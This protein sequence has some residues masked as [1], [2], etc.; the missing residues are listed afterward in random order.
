MLDRL[1]LDKT[2]FVT[3]RRKRAKTPEMVKSVPNVTLF[4]SKH[5][6]T[7]FDPFSTHLW[8]KGHLRLILSPFPPE[9]MLY[10]KKTRLFLSIL[11]EN[12]PKNLKSLKQV[13]VA[14]CVGQVFSAAFA[15]FLL[16]HGKKK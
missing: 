4:G 12:A 3:F 8:G 6:F 13:F 16:V 9:I 2:C 11:D 5:F 15:H 10:D 7:K 14:H 1:F